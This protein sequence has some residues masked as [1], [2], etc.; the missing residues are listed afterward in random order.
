MATDGKN[1]LN[2]SAGRS[3]VARLEERIRQLESTRADLEETKR[4]LDAEKLFSES[5]IASLPGLFFMVDEQGLYQRWNRNMEKV[6]GFTPEEIMFRD[7]RDFVPEADKARILQALEL[8]YDTGSFTLEYENQTKDG[9]PIPYFAQGVSVEVDG[10][11]F[12]LGVELD[13]SELKEAEKALRQSEEH[14]RSLMET[15]T[16]FVVYRLAFEQGDP[17]RA[18]V[19]FASP[20][21][22]DILG[23]SDPGDLGQWFSNVHP[24]DRDRIQAAHYQIP[25]PDRTEETMR[26]Y[27]PGKGQWRWVQ[28]LATSIKDDK[29][30][31]RYS[32]GIIIDATDRINAERELR[33]KEDELQ[34][35]AHKLAKTNTALQVLVEH[36]EEEITSTEHSILNTLERLV[37]PYLDDLE[38]TRLTGD[39]RTCLEIIRANLSRVTS[40]L[41]KKLSTWQHRLTPAEIKVADL[42]RNGRTTKEIADL[43]GVSDYSVS[44]H[45]KNLR[46]K[47]GLVGRRVN[48]TAFLQSQD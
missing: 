33:R 9:Q 14:L 45:R 26:V 30:I 3:R 20:S 13:M 15:A 28:F 2:H 10:R 12:V 32:N 19:V 11:R 22:H 16:N 34:Q 47:L 46:A 27:H 23:L 24:E 40:P 6:L 44:F 29:G 8:A 21:I 35:Q 25:R 41:S 18:R 36:R 1:G 4:Q 42:I 31:L 39:Q 5:I 38:Q 48:L 17:E 7:C 37:N 43:L